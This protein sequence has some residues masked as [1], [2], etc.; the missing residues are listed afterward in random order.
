M[1]FLKYE[2]SDKWYFYFKASKNAPSMS[3]DN[4]SSNFW[5]FF[6]SPFSVLIIVNGAGALIGAGRLI[7]NFTYGLGRVLGNIGAFGALKVCTT[8]L[9]SVI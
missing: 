9:G 6:D 5:S 4:K 8:I 7:F 2:C 1:P 3:F